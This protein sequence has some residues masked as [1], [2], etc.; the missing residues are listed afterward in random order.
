MKDLEKY[1]DYEYYNEFDLEF[2][3]IYTFMTSNYFMSKIESL[4]ENK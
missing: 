2:K 3:S 1:K 4:K